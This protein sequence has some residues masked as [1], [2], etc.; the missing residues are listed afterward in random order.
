[1]FKFVLMTG[2]FLGSLAGISGVVQ[3]A[4]ERGMTEQVQGSTR[5]GNH[6][7]VGD[8]VYENVNVGGGRTE[9]VYGYVTSTAWGGTKVWVQFDDP[10]F[11]GWCDSDLVYPA[12]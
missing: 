12:P 2:A 4:G 10:Q 6:Y 3:A 8:W 1:M 11:N 5:W 7:H 9:K